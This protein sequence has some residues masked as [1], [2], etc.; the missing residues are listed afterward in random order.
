M[1]YRS[2]WGHPVFLGGQSAENVGIEPGQR[3][4]LYTKLGLGINYE[5][6]R[7]DR[8]RSSDPQ[9]GISQCLNEE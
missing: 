4:Y 2:I 3:Y 5:W 6:I 8:G 1:A 9:F 7:T